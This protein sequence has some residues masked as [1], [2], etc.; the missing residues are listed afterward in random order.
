M[1]AT[2]HLKSFPGHKGIPGHQGGSAP[3]GGG[4]SLGADKGSGGDG[5]SPKSDA[6]IDKALEG[7]GFSSKTKALRSYATI[8]M[9]HP[10]IALFYKGAIDGGVSAKDALATALFM[11][12]TYVNGPGKAAKYYFEGSSDMPEQLDVA[13]FYKTVKSATI[14]KWR[15]ALDKLK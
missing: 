13:G 3:K 6:D 1:K 4:V 7:T 9:K 8:G 15:D 2:I 11:F 10:K 12:N 14:E 5:S